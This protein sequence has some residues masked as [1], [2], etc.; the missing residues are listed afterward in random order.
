MSTIKPSARA[1]T[2]AA[3][4]AAAANSVRRAEKCRDG[5]FRMPCRWGKRPRLS[6][7]VFAMSGSGAERRHTA[8]PAGRGRGNSLLIDRISGAKGPKSASSSFPK[9]W[10]DTGR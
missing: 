3:A 1:Q 2:A 6:S 8:A 10:K 9:S 4:A 5:V 7:K